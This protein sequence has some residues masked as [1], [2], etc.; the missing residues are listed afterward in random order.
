MTW[1]D[2][3][4]SYANLGCPREGRGGEVGFAN[5]GPSFAAEAAAHS[6]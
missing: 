5:L 1:D 2:V 3:A 6:V 4:K